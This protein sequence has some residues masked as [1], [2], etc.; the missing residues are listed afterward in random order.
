MIMV[1]LLIGK[2]I[3]LLPDG[4]E[5]LPAV[6]PM[7]I[8]LPGAVLYLLGRTL[9]GLLGSRGVPELS[10]MVLLLSV[11]V[12]AVLCWFLIPLMGIEGAAWA[13]TTS[14]VVLLLALILIVRKRYS[15]RVK[16]CLWLN[17]ND[18]KIIMKS[19]SQK[20]V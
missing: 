7:V 1:I 6:R 11:V 10:A 12:N 14:G 2:S 20:D 15:I 17:K 3:I 5:F 16:N 9:M 18:V 19:L 4:R 13:F 8:L